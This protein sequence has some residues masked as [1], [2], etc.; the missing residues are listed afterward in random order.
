[1][2]TKT[3]PSTV[4]R[5]RGKGY[6][7]GARKEKPVPADA[8]WLSSAQVRA[9]Y[10]D[11]SATWLWRHVHFD[12][13]FPRPSYHGRLQMFQRLDFDNY[14]AGIIAGTIKGDATPPRKADARKI[15]A[16]VSS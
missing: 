15:D 10:G 14:D 4:Q 5:R 13:D 7:L 3:K 9:R 8:V 2:A 1:M 11:R 16:G 12:P 6:K